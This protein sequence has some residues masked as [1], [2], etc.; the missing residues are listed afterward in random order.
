V[1]DPMA[2][3]DGA[4][5]VLASAGAIAAIEPAGVLAPP[6]GG[7][8]IDCSG[9]WIM[10]GLIDPH[11]HLRD[12]GFPAKE[13]IASGL[14]A[15]AAGGFTA[16]AAMAN[17]SPV[18]DTPEIAR[19]MIERAREVRG[20]R[21]IPVSA[22]TKGLQ[23]RELVDFAAM[24]AAGARMFSDDGI[25]IDDQ[26]VLR[27]AFDEARGCGLAISLHEEDRALTGDGAMNAGA[28]S[29]RLG[30]AGIP[31]AAET[32]RVRRDLAL[33]IGT[34]APVH[35]AHLS[36]ADSIGLVRAAR[37]SGANITC[38]AAPHHFT[39]DDSAVLEW[40]PDA[41]MAPP[42]RNRADVE[43]ICA[44]MADGAI[45][46][47]A[48]DH[49]PH[50]PS[51][52]RMDRFGAIF[53]HGRAAPRLSEEDARE[54]ARAANGIVGL[55]TAVGL[56]LALVH[57]GVIGPSRMAEMMSANPARLLRLD[58][59]GT[60][61]AGARADITLL[62]PNHEWTVEPA[63]F[64]SKSRNTPFA[65]MRLRGKAV[66]TMVAG[67]IVYDRRGGEGS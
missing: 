52:K 18:N 7:G 49:A 41:R 55:E 4:F 26:A 47:I 17:T 51:S 61:A 59:A 58:G 9:L 57:R 39:L 14:R 36:A 67:E 65:G 34:E 44:A 27:R 40:G 21:L 43:A 29:K 23:G 28:A 45:G 60:L 19:Y 25:P 8:V 16:V 1:I 20:A 37:K 13:T 32:A 22:V 50:D 46:M 15:A 11:V 53:G 66:M 35:I 56:A 62:D 30:V 2:G 10:P 12:P 63:R 6:D 31:A 48:T 24:A 5:D 3:I 42:L 54:L 64:E 38:E 33:A